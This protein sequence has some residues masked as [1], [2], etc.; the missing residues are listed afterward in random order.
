LLSKYPDDTVKSSLFVKAY[1]SLFIPYPSDKI[2]KETDI[3][4]EEIENILANIDF[5]KLMGNPY[6]FQYLDVKNLEMLF[7][8]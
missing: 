7:D 4:E 3:K 6:H 5:N 2:I 1:I 8:Y